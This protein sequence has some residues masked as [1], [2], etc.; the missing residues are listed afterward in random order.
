VA[1][2]REEARFGAARRIGLVAG[3]RQRAFAFGAIGDVAADALQFGGLAGVAADQSF[4]PGDPAR[5]ERTGDLLV[6]NPGA[7][8]FERGVALFD[9]P[10]PAGAADQS[11]AIHLRQFAIGVIGESDAAIGVAQHDQVAL[12][13]EQAAGALL[14]FLQFP[15]PVGHRFV[16]HGDLAHLL[17]QHAEAKTHGG[18]PDASQREQE[19]DADRKGVRVVA[20]IL[21]P[22]ACDESVGAAEG[23]GEHHE[24]AND[25]DEPGMTAGEAAKMQFD[26]EHPPHRQRS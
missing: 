24:G 25:Q 19:G 6:V 17:A 14:G 22:A 20:G 26:P 10:E 16:V 8:G 1:C 12:R 11:V 18:E 5:A 21:R 4:A 7:V 2:H 9:H 3:L 15:V 23:G 13:F